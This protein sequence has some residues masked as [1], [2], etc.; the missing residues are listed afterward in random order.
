MIA[1]DL[2]ISPVA[3]HASN[4]S[5]PVA[6]FDEAD[7]TASAIGFRNAC[8]ASS[9]MSPYHSRLV[10]PYPAIGKIEKLT[11]VNYRFLSLEH[12]ERR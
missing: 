12:D 10:S 1:I 5:S 6:F 9:F 7:F 2:C 11:I 8:I 3:K 4:Q